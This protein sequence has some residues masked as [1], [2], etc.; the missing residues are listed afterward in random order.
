MRTQ[1]LVG[2]EWVTDTDAPTFD[3][4]SYR[5]FAVL[6]GVRNGEGFAGC[7]TGD[8]VTPIAEPRGLPPELRD[9]PEDFDNWL[10]D[11][12]HSWLL[13]SEVVAY[14]WTQAVAERGYVN[15]P[16]YADWRDWNRAEN[17]PPKSWCG[18]VSGPGIKHVSAEEMERLVVQ[19]LTAHPVD[20]HDIVAKT[21]GR[22]YCLIEWNPP[23]ARSCQLFWV[24]FMPALIRYCNQS[25]G[26]DSVRLVFGFDS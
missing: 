10:G 20:G 7:D 23:V 17:R 18:G 15:G 16:V 1:R 14:D 2:G 12:S 22:T 26:P 19:T 5:T 13:A 6:A 3:D 8:A 24:E 4:R 25:G 11:H 9:E 21:L